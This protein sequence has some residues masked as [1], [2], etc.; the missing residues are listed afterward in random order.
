MKFNITFSKRAKKDLQGLER[1]V[2]KRINNAIK[3]KLESNHTDHL[4][5]LSGSLRGLYKFRVGD[6]RLVCK[7]EESKWIILIVTIKHRREV[8]N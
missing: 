8:Y 5:P 2:Q 3:E 1:S 6:Y 7:K 4:L